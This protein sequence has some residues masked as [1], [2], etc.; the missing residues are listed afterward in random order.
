MILVSNT[1]DFLLLCVEKA[2]WE[3]SKLLKQKA[4]IFSISGL[5]VVAWQ[6]ADH[7]LPYDF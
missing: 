4:A 3:E 7:I 1:W 6:L 2:A 5:L